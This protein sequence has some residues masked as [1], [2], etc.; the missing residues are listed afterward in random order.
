MLVGRESRASLGDFFLLSSS[1][2]SSTGDVSFLSI[3]S[4]VACVLNHRRIKYIDGNNA[5]LLDQARSELM[6]QEH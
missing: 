1:R 5:H 6:K 2:R 3:R 4:H